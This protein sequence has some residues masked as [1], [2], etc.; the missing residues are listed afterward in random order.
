M[1]TSI[2]TDLR[3]VAAVTTLYHLC[4]LSTLEK[5]AAKAKAYSKK[6]NTNNHENK[7]HT[8][9]PAKA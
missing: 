2:D 1:S 3:K 7:N 9:T 4:S 8:G 6:F 5:L